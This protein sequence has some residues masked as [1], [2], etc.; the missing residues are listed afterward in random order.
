MAV[1]TYERL[2]DAGEASSESSKHLAGLKRQARG[3]L[4]AVS[5]RRGLGSLSLSVAHDHPPSFSRPDATAKFR[6][7]GATAAVGTVGTTLDVRKVERPNLG[8]V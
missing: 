1:R 8:A 5:A 7:V 3:F 4:T 2:V 6:R